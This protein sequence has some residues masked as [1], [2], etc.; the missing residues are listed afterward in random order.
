MWV[1][2]HRSLGV[3]LGSLLARVRSS[4]ICMGR[5]NCT[6]ELDVENA[7]TNSRRK[8]EVKLQRCATLISVWLNSVGYQMAGE[9]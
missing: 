4:F 8:N 3:L 7:R 2:E 5:V 1:V 9:K 6:W